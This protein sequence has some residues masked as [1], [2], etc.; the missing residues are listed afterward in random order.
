MTSAPSKTLP[1]SSFPPAPRF[2]PRHPS[3]LAEPTHTV[4]D[5]DPKRRTTI[6]SLQTCGAGKSWVGIFT[7][8]FP[9]VYF[10][11]DWTVLA[12]RLQVVGWVV[13][14]ADPNRMVLVDDPER[15][16]FSLH[17][18]AEG[19]RPGAFLFGFFH[20]KKLVL[21]K[22]KVTFFMSEFHFAK[23]LRFRFS[24]TPT[25]TPRSAREIV[26][27]LRRRGSP[28]VTGKHPN[29][30]KGPGSPAEGPGRLDG[31]SW[32]ERLG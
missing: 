17:Q 7:H 18:P 25:P 26:W 11:L 31:A 30:R 12:G 23:S 8:G 20:R 16:S 32:A 6:F 21:G 10:Y 22:Q 2:P 14:P 29:R 27:D 28:D 9:H 19:P 4:L 24:S 1:G 13:Q 15:G 3:E 5:A